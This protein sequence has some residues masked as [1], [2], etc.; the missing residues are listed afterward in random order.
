MGLYSIHIYLYIYTVYEIESRCS[1]PTLL[2][3]FI[4]EKHTNSYDLKF[5][6]MICD[7]MN[8]THPLHHKKFL[9]SIMPPINTYNT[10]F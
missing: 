5:F 3:F 8:S 4:T 10:I 7:T 1:N 2:K 9:Q 6:L